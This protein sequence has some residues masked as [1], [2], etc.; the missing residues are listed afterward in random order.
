MLYQQLS[1]IRG[2]LAKRDLSVSDGLLLALRALRG[3]F[4]ES[5][6]TWL[7]RELLGYR[8]EDLETLG[9]KEPKRGSFSKIVLMWAPTR[10]PEVEAPNFRFLAGTW[11]RMDAHGQLSKVAEPQ[12]M[13]KSIFCNIGIQQLEAQLS[14]M[15]DPLEGLFSMSFDRDTGAEFFCYS[16]EL[17]RIQDAVREKLVQFIDDSIEELRLSPTSEG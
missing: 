5:R 11:G 1:R 10:K 15:E 14:E 9:E 16:R 4:S 17:V 6:L 12:L 3:K 7:N 13:E 8:P 2:Q